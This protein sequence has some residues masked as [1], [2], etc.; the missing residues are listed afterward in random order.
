MSISKAKDNESILSHTIVV[1]ITASQYEKLEKISKLSDS[2]TIANVVRK[3][4]ANRPI[5]L[6]H[7]DISMNAPMEEMALIRKEIK[8]IGVNINQ[9]TH[10]YHASTSETE[11]SF[12]S[13]KTAETY[14]SIEPKIDQLMMIISKLAE[15]WL[16]E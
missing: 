6:L 7:K 16:Q 14:K 2:R 9:Q 5:K 8:S 4:L 1:R 11:R 12:H 3:I 10:R 15:K 13:I